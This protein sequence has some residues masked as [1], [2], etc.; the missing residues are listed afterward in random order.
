M[1]VNLQTQ[2]N[3]RATD[4]NAEAALLATQAGS[5]APLLQ[6]ETAVLATRLRWQDGWDCESSGSGLFRD[7]TAA[8]KQSERELDSD[9]RA[10]RRQ[11]VRE[12]ASQQAQDRRE[13]RTAMH[14]KG[15][16]IPVGKTESSDTTPARSAAAEADSQPR[17]VAK[18]T[19]RATAAKLTPSTPTA[20]TNGSAPRESN[21][22][23]VS[24]PVRNSTVGVPA[25]LTHLR[26]A[27]ITAAGTNSTAVGLPAISASAQ[28]Q[29]ARPAPTGGPRGT[30]I[31]VSNTTDS[32]GSSKPATAATTKAVTGQPADNADRTEEVERI[33]RI[34]A[35]RINGKNSHT[36]M[37]LDPA[38]LGSMRLQMDLRGDVMTLR[39]D[40]STHVAHRLLSGEV[41]KLREGLEEAGVRLERIEVRPP[42]DAPPVDDRSCTDDSE[43][44]GE[45]QAGSEQTGTEQP[46]QHGV[47][48][49]SA[50]SL[51]E[52]IPITDSE[53]VAESLVN[54]IA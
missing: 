17:A 49:R 44:R 33:V 37:R 18:S 46:R 3:T 52:V 36:V 1:Q 24:Q 35:S 20:R 21:A 19:Q 31:G 48:F 22:A 9:S 12:Q 26:T 42:R 38:E 15:D 40:T 6:Q 10:F 32:R 50:G 54:V 28:T 51:D 34:F 39:V 4:T 43:P 11:V 16:K 27:S 53:P 41:E 2:P 30:V 45:Q 29:T 14:S 13:F 7:S 47:S 5:F 23:P 25:V 8:I